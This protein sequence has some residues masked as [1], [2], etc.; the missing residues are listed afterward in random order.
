MT[1]AVQLAVIAVVA[2]LSTG[3]IVVAVGVWADG[4]RKRS[5]ARVKSED[6]AQDELAKVHD[7]DRKRIAKLEERLDQKDTEIRGLGQQL[8]D[9]RVIVAQQA[10][11]IADLEADLA[12]LH[13]ERDRAQANRTEALSRDTNSRIR[14]GDIGAGEKA[15]VDKA[16][17][18]D[19][20]TTGEDTNARIRAVEE[21]QS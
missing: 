4:R 18:N 8:Y 17:A 20:Q 10:A 14:A 11:K 15:I 9:A 21:H 6:K 12:A 1:E 2:S 13:L 5:D 3:T 7:E 16:Q 19:I